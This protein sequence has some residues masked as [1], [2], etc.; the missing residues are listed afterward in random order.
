M[1]APNGG[2]A[3]ISRFFF[4]SH[5]NFILLSLSCQNSKGRTTF[6]SFRPTLRKNADKPQNTPTVCS[7]CGT[8]PLVHC[9]AG[10]LGLIELHIVMMTKRALPSRLH[11]SGY[12][13]SLPFIAGWR[14]IPFSW[15][16]STEFRR[17]GDQTPELQWL[18]VLAN[19][20]ATMS[21]KGQCSYRTFALLHVAWWCKRVDGHSLRGGAARAL[22]TSGCQSWLH[23]WKV[24]P[25]LHQ[26]GLCILVQPAEGTH[27]V[28]VPVVPRCS[29][30]LQRERLPQRHAQV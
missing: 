13:C 4:L 10:S 28:G 19:P 7:T 14:A 8:T 20:N 15:L 11:I 3:N 5:H 24:W 17:N 30:A 26:R 16:S 25:S 9:H 2:G 22:G 27:D 1:E 6:A 12:L 23:Y 18:T 21:S 29:F